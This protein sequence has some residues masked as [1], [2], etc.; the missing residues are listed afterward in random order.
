LKR[1]FTEE[2]LAELFASLQTVSPKTNSLVLEFVAHRFV[3]GKAQEYAR[4]GFARRIQTLGRCVQN[5]FRIIPPGVAEVPS[6]H[7]LYDVQINIQAAIANAYGCVDNLAW[8]WVHEQ[9]LSIEPRRVGLRKHNAAV[10]ASL[11]PYFRDYL[12]TREKWFAYLTEYRDALAHR[13]PLYIPPGNVRPKDID[14]YN[15]LT[16]RMDTAINSFR[17]EEYDRLSKEQEKLLVFQ[18]IM[19]HSLGEMTAPYWFHVQLLADFATAEELGSKML[20]ELRNAPRDTVFGS[21]SRLA[22]DDQN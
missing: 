10:R 5:V 11:S 7:R 12:D 4:H 16:T 9:G 15:D 8:V 22:R 3:S 6:K 18:P 17:P 20:A 21:R 1:P 14:A 19:G 13:I 2:R